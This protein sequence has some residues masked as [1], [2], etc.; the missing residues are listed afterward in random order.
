M[1]SLAHP[2]R[3]RW[4]T[5]PILPQDETKTGCS[6]TPAALGVIGPIVPPAPRCAAPAV[7]DRCCRNMDW[8]DL[9]RPAVLG[10]AAVRR[11]QLFSASDGGAGAG[12]RADDR[13]A[14][15]D[16]LG[17][18]PPRGPADLHGRP[19]KE[20]DAHAGVVGSASQ[21]AWGRPTPVRPITVE[22]GGTPHHLLMPST[23]GCRARPSGAGAPLPTRS[24]A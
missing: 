18:R 12:D 8:V 11:Q 19:A 6:P 21:M 4:Q 2:T 5:A 24:S 22:L 15:R 3:C 23:L 9:M 16:W 1:R 13:A 17:H 14:G 7:S 10:A 20:A